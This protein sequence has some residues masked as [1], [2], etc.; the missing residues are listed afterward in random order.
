ME[1]NSIEF[2]VEDAF[3][4]ALLGAWCSSLGGFWINVYTL[5][6]LALIFLVF[7]MIFRIV[8]GRYDPIF[9]VV[10]FFLSLVMSGYL[11]ERLYRAIEVSKRNQISFFSTMLLV[12]ASIC[13]IKI[14]YYIAD[15]YRQ[16]HGG[17]YSG[18][19]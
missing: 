7:G 1:Q 10:Y 15:R 3:F 14:A 6:R 13:F 11:L 18:N 19:A 5:I 9:K 4:G 16:K 2:N 17:F 12:W 8:T